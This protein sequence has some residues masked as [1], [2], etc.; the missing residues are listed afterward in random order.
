MPDSLKVIHDTI[1]IKGAEAYDL[2]NKID[3]FYRSGWDNLVI[4]GTAIAAVV[5]VL[6]PVYLEHTKKKRYINDK[7]ADRNFF[8]E[9]IRETR[10]SLEKD[11][12]TQIATELTTYNAGVERELNIARASNFFIM[13]D[14]KLDKKDY[15]FAFVNF[16]ACIRYSI[17]AGDIGNIKSVLI[18]L[19][20]NCIPHLTY[21]EIRAS[22]Q[23][24]AFNVNEILN[25][26]S[27]LNN[28]TLLFDEITLVKHELGRIAGE[29]LKKQQH[30]NGKK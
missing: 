24:Y 19:A 11:I 30:P 4:V 3:A 17:T 15:Q 8:A 5:G 21:V 25:K 6:I 18:H 2:V 14:S 10:E 1:Y 12:K 29:E 28:G 20:K 23:L 27:S 13:G 22:E 7:Q 26:I 16:I 9:K